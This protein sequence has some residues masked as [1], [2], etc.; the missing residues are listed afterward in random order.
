MKIN[1]GNRANGAGLMQEWVRESAAHLRLALERARECDWPVSA[2][3]S[4]SLLLGGM[5]GSAM[6]CDLAACFLEGRIPVQV[7]RDVDPPAWVRHGTPVG[8]VSYSGHTWET[9]EIARVCREAGAS[10]WAVASGGPLLSEAGLEPEECFEVPAGFAPRAAALWLLVPVALAAGRVAGVDLDASLEEAADAIEEELGLWA[11]GDALP[12]R[13]PARIAE[14]IAGRIAV[15]YTPSERLRPLGVRWKNQL[16]E[17]AKQPAYEAAFPEL[18]HN[19]IM[20][21]KAAADAGCLV[22]LVL[23]DPVRMDL[24]GV[25][26]RDASIRELETQ[27]GRVLRIPGRAGSLPVRIL[28]HLVLADQVSLEVAALRGIDPLPVDAIE[29][30]KMACGK[31]QGA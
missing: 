20:G 31:E 27:G 21:W 14:E 24:R 2:R 25:R 18:A 19:E 1:G 3:R 12:G 4:D 26:V 30:V 11:A 7:L 15:V 29:R 16:L 23:E 10:I 5:G 6:A 17:N 22:H 9:L 28:S 8:L 13:D